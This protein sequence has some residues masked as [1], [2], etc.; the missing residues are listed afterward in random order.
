[1]YSWM[2]RHDFAM[3]EIRY[4]IF[5]G[6]IRT[7]QSLNGPFCIPDLPSVSVPCHFLC[8]GSCFFILPD[9]VVWE[10]FVDNNQHKA[11]DSVKHIYQ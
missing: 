9:L 1:M 11:E 5:P 10:P 7:T 6:S 4:S 3:Y 2:A 8:F